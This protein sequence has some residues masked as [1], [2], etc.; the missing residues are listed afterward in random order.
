MTISVQHFISVMTMKTMI[1]TF[2]ILALKAV[3]LLV[4]RVNNSKDKITRLRLFNE[5]VHLVP[6]QWNLI[7]WAKGW[8]R[9]III[10]STL[11]LSSLWQLLSNVEDFVSVPLHYCTIIIHSANQ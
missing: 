2:P 1:M 5:V 6:C 11:S 4:I 7:E 10:Y 9:Y 8:D 3:M